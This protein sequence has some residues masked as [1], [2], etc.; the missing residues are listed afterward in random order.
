MK[1]VALVGSPR[2]GRGNTAA[3]VEQ[4]LEGVRAE[5]SR[6]ETVF[7]PGGTVLPCRAC[8][9]CH[10][11]GSCAQKDE[12]G[13][14]M[15]KIL[16]ADGLIVA[17]PNYIDHVSAQLK[18]FIDRCCGVVH[19]LGFRGRYGATVVTSGGGPEEMIA[20]YLERYLIVTG[21]IPVGSVWATIGR[22]VQVFSEE[23]KARARDLGR[24][25]V[26]ACRNK[27]SFPE[28]EQEL[29]AF[30]A[31]MEWLMN[32]RKDLWTYEYEYWKKHMGL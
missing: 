21:I 7:L 15:E 22:Q 16:A 17:S 8:D 1:I 3:L 31:R 25:L 6:D 5:G 28:K 14:I 11:T 18:A 29:S 23:T 19:L 24:R 26:Q 13:A 9:L 2:K 10:V 30:R 12:F 20:R 32:D 4:V 27:E